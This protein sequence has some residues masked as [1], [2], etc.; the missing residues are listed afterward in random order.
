MKTRPHQARGN[1][2][3]ALS[4]HPYHNGGNRTGRHG[5]AA[6]GPG[7]PEGTGAFRPCGRA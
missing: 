2:R 5:G 1:P 4:Q 7:A 3:A 6:T